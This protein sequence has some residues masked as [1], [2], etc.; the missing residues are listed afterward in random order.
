VKTSVMPRILGMLMGMGASPYKERRQPL[1][2]VL[3]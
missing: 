1:S 3:T 2:K